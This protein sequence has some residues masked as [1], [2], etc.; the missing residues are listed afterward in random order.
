M[1]D[2]TRVLVR[3]GFDEPALN[4]AALSEGAQGLLAH[5]LQKVVS[6]ETT[7][8]EVLA[9]AGAGEWHASA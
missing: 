4:R 6:G 3:A 8:A 5:G 1:S 9:V 2:A 7:V